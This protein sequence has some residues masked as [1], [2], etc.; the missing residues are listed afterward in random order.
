MSRFAKAKRAHH[1]GVPRGI[2][3]LVALISHRLTAA[4]RG[5]RGKHLGGGEMRRV[6]TRPRAVVT[7][8]L[9]SSAGEPDMYYGAVLHN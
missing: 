7:L 4:E 2:A 1:R 9:P 6:A 8:A 5:A 3:R